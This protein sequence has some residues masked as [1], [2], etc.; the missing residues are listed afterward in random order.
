MRHRL[1]ILG[2]LTLMALAAACA[3]ETDDGGDVEAT[4]QALSSC[5]YNM[6]SAAVQ[7]STPRVAQVIYLA[8]N[9]C[10]SGWN[11]TG[12]VTDYWINNNYEGYRPSGVNVYGSWIGDNGHVTCT[13]NNGTGT[14]QSSQMTCNWTNYPVY[15]H[16]SS[17]QI[18]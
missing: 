7:W 13:E 11:G 4:E 3:S 10:A 14:H 5:D 8:K 17:G 15:G 6:H 12:S 2:Y 1:M 18:N 9:A 16:S